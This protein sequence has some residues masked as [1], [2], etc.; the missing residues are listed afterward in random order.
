[1]KD[2][3][4][5]CRIGGHTI[6]LDKIHISTKNHITAPLLPRGIVDEKK[7]KRQ[8]NDRPRNT[9]YPKIHIQTKT[10]RNES[11]KQYETENDWLTIIV[12]DPRIDIKLVIYEILTLMK[13]TTVKSHIF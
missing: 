8:S 7:S 12:L 13:A 1:V 4:S 9:W 2:N 3:S 10:I 11:Q 5:L 6:W